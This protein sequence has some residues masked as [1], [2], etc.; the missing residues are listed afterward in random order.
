MDIPF[1]DLKKQFKALEK[2]V[3]AAMDRVLAH[4]QF[5]LGPEVGRLE[6]ELSRFVGVRH[7]IGCGSGTEAL[8]MALMA[9]EVGPGDAVFTSPFT[10]VA[11][12]EVISLVGARPVFVDIEPETF[13]LDPQRLES[14]VKAVKGEGRFRARGVIPVD[15]FGLPADYD[16][17]MALAEEHGLF[18]LGDAA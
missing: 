14:A 3:R 17:I 11:T 1:V 5:I 16:P 8:L 10:F 15:L 12:A 18:V 4:G 6:E 7:A 9:F 2:E 13:N